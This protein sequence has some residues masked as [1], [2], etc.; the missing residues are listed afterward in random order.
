MKPASIVVLASIL[1]S[2]T[3]SAQEQKSPAV[4]PMHSMVRP[5][6]MKWGPGP[7]NLPKGVQMVVLSGDP[8]KAEMSVVRAKM[9]AGYKIPPHWHPTDEQLT[10]LSGTLS[11]GMADTF[12][13]AKSTDLGPGGWALM[14]A[15]VHHFAWTKAGCTIQV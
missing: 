7:P 15:T 14:P 1:L 9:P 2:V 13:P 11:M 10:V 3:G 5:G 6:Q 12:D 4:A 8:T